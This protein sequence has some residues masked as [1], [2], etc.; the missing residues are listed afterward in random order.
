[1]VTTLR[2]FY[3]AASAEQKAKKTKTKKKND[4]DGRSLGHDDDECGDF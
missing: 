1:M 2:T 4:G 3:A